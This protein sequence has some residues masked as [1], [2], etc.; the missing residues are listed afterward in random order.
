M[1]Y[2]WNI[3]YTK[4]VK[5]HPSLSST[6]Q[7]HQ[8]KDKTQNF[9]SSNKE[10]TYVLLYTP[11]VWCCLSSDSLVAKNVIEETYGTCH[12]SWQGAEHSIKAGKVS[13]CFPE[14]LLRKS[15]LSILL[16]IHSLSLSRSLP[17][18]I[19]Q[20]LFLSLLFPC[21]A[22]CKRTKEKWEIEKM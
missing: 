18:S 15:I 17:L 3:H 1:K 11:V 8:K 10:G 20:S 9:S 4:S 13:S 22:S 2:N 21:Y 19:C 16:P 5:N 12:Q 7:I 14:W 6:P